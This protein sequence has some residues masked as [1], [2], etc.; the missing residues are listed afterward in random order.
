MCV[1]V[2]VLG[3][4]YVHYIHVGT[5]RG[6]IPW[7]WSSKCLCAGNQTSLL[8]EPPIQLSCTPSSF[9]FS[10]IPRLQPMA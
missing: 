1:C 10:C 9:S 5:Y 4:M 2:C 3:C 8:Q 7:N 6:Q